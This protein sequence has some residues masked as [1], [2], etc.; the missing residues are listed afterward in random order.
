MRLSAVYLGVALMA[1]GLSVATASAQDT[2]TRQRGVRLADGHADACSANYSQCMT[3]CDG[4]SGCEA[5]CQT[6]Y[7]GCMDQGQ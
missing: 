3:G 5:Q 2:G 1:L 6:N 4:M 7:D